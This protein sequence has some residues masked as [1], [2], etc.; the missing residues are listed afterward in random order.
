MREKKAVTIRTSY[1]VSLTLQGRYYRRNCDRRKGK[2]YA[3]IYAGLVLLGI[4][5]RCTPALT[6][7]IGMLTVT[8]G[9]LAETQ[10]VLAE[11]GQALDVKTLRLIA[12]RTAERVRLVQKMGHYGCEPQ[13]SVAGRRVVVSTDG[14]R[15]RLRE[16]KRG[17]KTA[18]GRNRYHGAWREPKLFVIYVV[19]SE[20]RQLPS[21]APFIDGAI[22]GPDSLFA[23]LRC[24]LQALAIQA[25]DQ[26]LFVADGA[27]WI[28][29]RLPAL[30]ATLGID[31]QR[32]HLL[33]DFYHAVEHLSRVAALRKDWSGKVRRRWVKQQRKALLAGHVEGVIE[34]IRPLCR[35]RHSK[36]IRTELNYFVK[37]RQHMAYANIASLKLPIGS[38]AIESAIRR[39]VNLRLKGPAIFW[40][41]QNAEALLMLRA[42]YKSGRWQQLKAMAFSALYALSL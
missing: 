15:I 12:Y 27:T 21:Y 34:A 39:V 13:D 36:A 40:C 37:H 23:L 4:Y 2:R 29:H 6:S 7:E 25:A 41:K 5:E 30:L 20:G 18:K 28:W 16:K 35:G 42:Y 26:L 11:Q 1:G 33:I 19:D 24:Y 8:L 22:R 31:A 38:G 32:V 10:Q 14:G 9:S 3:G 17:P